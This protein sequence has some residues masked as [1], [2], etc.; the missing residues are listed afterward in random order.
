MACA[1][2]PCRQLATGMIL[3]TML[4]MPCS[5]PLRGMQRRDGP[6]DA[7]IHAAGHPSS[8]KSF[9]GEKLS[10]NVR[11][12]PP[13]GMHP[14]GSLILLMGYGSDLSWT[15]PQWWYMHPAWNPKDQEWC[16]GD[17]VFDDFDKAAAL[18]LTNNLRIVD[19]VGNIVLAKYSH[20][21]YKYTVWP[22]G[23]P[24]AHEVEEAVTTVFQLIEREYAIVGDY[25]RIAI[26]GMSQ[27]ADLSLEVGMRF[28]HQ[29]GMVF[30]QRGVIMPSRR[31]SNQTWSASPGTPFI[32]TGGDKDELTSLATYKGDC[33]SLQWI[34]QTPVYFKAYYGLNHGDFSK[35]EWSLL[36]KAFGLMLNPN[37][38]AVQIE[39]LAHWD[40]CTA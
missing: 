28:P 6:K 2:A 24:I 16:K 34:M 38:K 1:R 37:P 18:H 26:A 9:I 12:Y 39:H 21:W 33:A 30:S 13:P 20:A 27:G 23:P 3:L 8:T 35:P 17:C 25:K 7:A 11:V 10:D 15:L 19:A 36:M 31:Q 14:V 29:L 32:M 5:M 40:S 22:D 4:E